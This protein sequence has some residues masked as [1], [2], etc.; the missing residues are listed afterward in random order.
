MR[1]AEDQL[2]MENKRCI[3]NKKHAEEQAR[4]DKQTSSSNDEGPLKGKGV[5]PGNWD[6]ANLG[7]SDLDIDA[8]MEV[9]ETWAKFKAQVSKKTKQTHGLE[10]D[11]HDPM[12]EA[13]KAAEQCITKAF[14]Q[15][16][17]LL[18]D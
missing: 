10:R 12:N 15:Q 16:I 9:L 8:Q 11:H 2:I 6:K 17:H 18:E 4:V 1:E 14:E 7:D 13:V 5:D 3:T